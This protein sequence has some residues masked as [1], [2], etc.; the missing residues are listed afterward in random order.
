MIAPCTARSWPDRGLIRICPILQ[1]VGSLGS[2]PSGAF[3]KVLFNEVSQV[4]CRRPLRCSREIHVCPACDNSVLS[5]EEQPAILPL[6]DLAPLQEGLERIRRGR[7]PL[8]RGDAAEGDDKAEAVFTEFG[9]GQLQPRRLLAHPPDA[10]ADL[11]DVAQ[12]QEHPR[13]DLVP[14]E[15]V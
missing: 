13:D 2:S 1:T 6:V 9:L 8:T 4:T 7:D 3:E 15:L 5:D 12:F 10:Q 14:R 11:L